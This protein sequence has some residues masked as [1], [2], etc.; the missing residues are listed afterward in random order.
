MP[1]ASLCARITTYYNIQPLF[2]SGYNSKTIFAAF[3][4][5][6]AIIWE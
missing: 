4:G 6:Q 2:E 3:F 5:A 1:M